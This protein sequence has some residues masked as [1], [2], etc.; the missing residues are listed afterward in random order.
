VADFYTVSFNDG[1]N[2]DTVDNAATPP[3]FTVF[4]VPRGAHAGDRC[5]TLGLTQNGVRTA[6]GGAACW[7]RTA[8]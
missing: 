8:S 7:E 2:P 1:V 3:V 6:T 5:G 4:A